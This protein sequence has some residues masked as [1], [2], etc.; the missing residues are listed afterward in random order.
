MT[1]IWALAAFWLTLALL[2]A[3]LAVRFRINL[4]LTEVVIGVLANFVLA[5]VLGIELIPRDTLWVKF[6]AGAGAIMLTFLAGAELDPQ[7]IRR[8]WREATAIGLASFIVPALAC[9]G[10]AH[11]LLGWSTD[12]GLLSGI[13]LSATSVAVVYTVMLETKLNQTTYGKTLLAACFVT[14]LA[15]VIALGLFFAPFTYKSVV[16][17]VTTLLAL[18]LMFRHG[19]ECLQRFG[20]RTSELEVRTLLVCLFGLGA[21]ALW[22]GNEA[23]LPAYLVGLLRRLRGLTF[24]LLTP[25][26]FIRAGSF[27]SIPAVLAALFGYLLLLSTEMG[28]KLLG[29][30]PVTQ[31]F[32]ASRDEGVFTTLLMATG[33]TFGTIAALYG[34]SHGIITQDQYSLL[35]ATIISTAVIPTL[36]AYRHFFPT[37]HLTPSASAT[38]TEN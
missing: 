33:L 27:V 8:Q 4:A 5:V 14:D 19:A 23:V 18:V 10:T 38:P 30:F 9:A 17:I 3:F 29:V 15:T 12:A 13:A 32:G 6:L 21:L 24:G 36:I 11:Y 28:A 16:F 25:F 20:N 35:V 37:H 22:S 26:Y 34:L 1:E 31:A 2:A 7:V